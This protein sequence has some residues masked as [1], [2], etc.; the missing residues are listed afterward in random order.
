[1]VNG[2]V[3]YY[4]SK[5]IWYEGLKRMDINKA[6]ALAMTAPGFSL[7][8][9]FI[10]LKETPTIYHFTGLIILSIGVYFTT[11]KP[12]SETLKTPPI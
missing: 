1:M 7:F 11:R 10:F 8:F 12:A 6:I 4:I 2:V 5:I 3:I 9:A